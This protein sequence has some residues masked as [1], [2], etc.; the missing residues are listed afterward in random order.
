VSVV[1]GTGEVGVLLSVGI[2]FKLL[3]YCFINGVIVIDAKSRS[4]K[5]HLR[6]PEDGHMGRN[7]L[8]DKNYKSV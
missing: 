4:F 5:E 3:V 2:L 1:L 8:L 6:G 7:M